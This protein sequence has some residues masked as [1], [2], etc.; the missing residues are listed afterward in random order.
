MEPQETNMPNTNQQPET[1]GSPE[2]IF[3]LK[4]QGINGYIITNFLNYCETGKLKLIKD[5]NSI[6]NDIKPEQREEIEM[7]CMQINYLI[8]E[9]ANLRMKKTKNNTDITIE[10]VVRKI[11]KDR[12]SALAYGLY[13]IEEFLNKEDPSQSWFD[14]D[15][16]SVFY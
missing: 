3:S 1:A 10:Q 12:Y 16:V 11:D 7:A 5:F 9:V 13:Y 14:N 15:E 2:F 8:D 6:K 4:S